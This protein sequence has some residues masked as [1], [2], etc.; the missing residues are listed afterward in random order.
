MDSSAKLTEFSP[1]K[2]DPVSED[3]CIQKVT[4]LALARN[5]NTLAQNLKH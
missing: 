4:A 2:V 5:A 1:Y 3:L